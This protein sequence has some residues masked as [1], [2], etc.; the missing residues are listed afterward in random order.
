MKPAI[1]LRSILAIAFGILTG[2]GLG[3]ESFAADLL[4]NEALANEPGSVTSLEWIELLNWPDTGNG[5]ISLGGYRLVDGRDTTLFDTNLSIP[6]GGFLILARKTLGNGS[7]ES[8]WGDSSGIWGDS[9]VESF[10]VILAKISLRNANDTVTLMSPS[11]DTSRM[12]WSHDPGD[13]VSL[14]RIRPNHDDRPAN[15]G[16]CRD[17]TGSTPGRINSVFP[18]RYDLALDSLRLTPSEPRWGDTIRVFAHIS[19]TGLG[20]IQ[21]GSLELFD[22]TLPSQASGTLIP[23]ASAP[24]SEIGEL[25]HDSVV[26]QWPDPPPGPHVLHARLTADG[27]PLNDTLSTATIVRFS[28]PLIIISEYLADPT[29]GGPDEWLEI[30]NRADFA[31]NLAGL[32]VGDS[33][34]ASPLPDSIGAIGPGEFWILTENEIAFRSHYPSFSGNLIPIPAWHELNNTG[35]R[36]RLIGAGDEIIDSVSYRGTYGDDHSTER[37]EMS[38]TFAGSGD[39]AESVDPL[40]GTPGRENTQRSD[41][42]GSFH[43]AVTPNPIYVTAGIPAQI[44]YRLNIG[45]RL[46]LKIFDLDGRLIRTLADQTPSATGS[47][48][49][50]GTDNSGARIRPGPYVLLA[51]SDPEGATTKLVIV[52]GP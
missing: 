17:T 38:A 8:V 42:A 5:F 44:E 18:V 51:R 15:F 20:P 39:W 14:E 31:I 10:P 49:W 22:G 30:S 29:V 13:G 2:M 35:D 26:I 25:E 46:T 27:N 37:L 40:G 43:V 36:I 1:R 11:G 12:L 33:S 4:I 48:Q 7:L 3:K 6:P 21:N 16:F 32:R 23:V 24:I 50:D 28:Q 45:E 47:A 19:N 41:R 34:G 9:P 52:V